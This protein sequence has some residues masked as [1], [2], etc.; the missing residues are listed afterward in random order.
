MRVFCVPLRAYSLRALLR[1]FSL[2]FTRVVFIK[3]CSG[4]GEQST[5]PLIRMNRRNAVH[6]SRQSDN[7]ISRDDSGTAAR[8]AVINVGA[9]FVY[10]NSISQHRERRY[11]GDVGIF[12]LDNRGG[13]LSWTNGAAKS[14]ISASKKQQKAWQARAKYLAAAWQ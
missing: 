5:W 14:S 13:V 9:L 7:D 11:G 10:E 3:Q 2:A 12:W 4:T 8:I 6:V 1:C